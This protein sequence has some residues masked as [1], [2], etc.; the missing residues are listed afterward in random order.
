VVVHEELKT[1]WFKYVQNTEGIFG[2]LVT[3]KVPNLSSINDVLNTWIVMF[4]MW[5]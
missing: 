4:V 3:Q 5:V 1:F 2:K